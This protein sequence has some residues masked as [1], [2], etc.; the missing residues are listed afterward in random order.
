MKNLLIIFLQ[1]ILNVHAHSLPTN[2]NEFC[3]RFQNNTQ[4]KS[5]AFDHENFISFKNNG[6]LFNGG[7]CWWHSRFQRNALYLT[8]LESNLPKPTESEAKIIIKEIRNSN[9][10]IVIPG[11]KNF[12]EF[13][14]ENQSL[15][16]K[17]LNAWQLFDGVVLGGW[18]DG[19]KGET[20]IDSELLRNKMNELND[21]VAVKNKIGYVKLQIKGITSHAWLI[22]DSKPETNGL[23]IGYI[24][25]NWPLQTNEYQ[26]KWGDQSFNLKS[27]GDFVP[28]LEFTR[29]EEKLNS[30]AQSFCNNQTPYL[31]D[32]SD[33]WQDMHDFENNL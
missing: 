11:Y 24:D 9:K 32:E 16:Q 27:Y 20:K 22:I 29:E 21:Y 18:I 31:L 25:S 7:V 1:L 14:H 5:M 26:Y 3:Q 28:Y 19:L 17:E 2:K 15:I 12:Q 6:G 33:Y 10:T 30:V 13:T 4:I 8:I 23:V